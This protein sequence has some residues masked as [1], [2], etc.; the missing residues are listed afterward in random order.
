M[1]MLGIS[2]VSVAKADKLKPE[3][4]IFI[5]AD[6]KNRRQQSLNLLIASSPVWLSSRNPHGGA[7]AWGQQ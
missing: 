3:I 5:N 1:Q 7:L 4:V 2:G 6:A